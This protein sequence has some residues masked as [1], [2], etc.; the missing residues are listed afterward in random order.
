MALIVFGG[1][2]AIAY[3]VTGGGQG[4][5]T[6]RPK[7]VAPPV[8]RHRT[9]TPRVLTREVTI[10]V[11]AVAKD[12]FYLVPVS[13]ATRSSGELLD[14]AL[15]ALLATP[16]ES[17]EAGKLIP[18]GTKARGP[19]KVVNGVAMVDLSREFV[20]NFSGGSTQESLILNSIA[21]TLVSNSGGTVSKVQILV[22]GKTVE[23]LDGHFDLS[24]PFA[25]ASDLLKPGSED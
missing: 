4:D 24:E 11:P 18:Q 23:E 21:H 19:V 5:R 10:F 8:A 25:P 17:G 13:R 15:Q 12:R 1:A 3:L 14:A 20:E 6:R 16:G 22:E 9:D 2:A 7:S